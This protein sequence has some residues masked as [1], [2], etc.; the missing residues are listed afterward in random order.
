MVPILLMVINI[1]A[2]LLVPV[3]T[4]IDLKANKLPSRK[5]FIPRRAYA[6]A[7]KNTHWTSHLKPN[8]ARCFSPL[9]SPLDDT[10]IA[11]QRTL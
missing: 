1:R 4:I 5:A 8:A 2:Y 3:G 6:S 7:I 11:G 9:Q 10:A